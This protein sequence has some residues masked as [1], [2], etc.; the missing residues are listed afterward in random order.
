MYTQFLKKMPPQGPGSRCNQAVPKQATSIEIARS[1]ARPE[2]PQRC[3]F[4]TDQIAFANGCVIF[5][6]TANT[7]P[8]FSKMPVRRLDPGD[9]ENCPGNQFF[10]FSGRRFWRARLNPRCPV[11]VLLLS[12]RS[13]LLLC[14][15]YF[16]LPPCRPGVACLSSCRRF[17][18]ASLSPPC[19]F[20]VAH[21]GTRSLSC[22]LPVAC[23]SF[24][25]RPPV[26]FL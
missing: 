22:C 19:C 1:G 2:N 25:C 23:L 15:Q 21:R 12:C 4:R 6:Q 10:G 18:V 20:P 26:A 14:C 13:S 11:A 5:G 8:K 3:D 9:R 24:A 16:L 7:A 17:S